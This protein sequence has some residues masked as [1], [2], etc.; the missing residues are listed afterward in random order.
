MTVLRT[1]GLLIFHRR[2]FLSD[3]GA[4]AYRARHLFR[5]KALFLQPFDSVSVDCPGIPNTHG[6]SRGIC[7]HASKD[8]SIQ[9]LLALC[10]LLISS[11]GKSVM[12]E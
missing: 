7:I 11:L 1:D 10:F 8:K 9:F 2:A 6:N 5:A 4:A 3:P 12:L